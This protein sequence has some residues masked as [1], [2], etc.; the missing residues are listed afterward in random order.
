MGAANQLKQAQDRFADAID[1]LTVLEANN[2]NTAAD[3]DAKT[4]GA[5]DT[6]IPLTSNLF[7]PGKV[8]R[9]AKEAPVLVDI[10]TGYFAEKSTEDAKDYFKRMLGCA[11]ECVCVEVVIVLWHSRAT[12]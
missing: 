6:L 1:S 7:V 3:S 11:N 9:L 5:A 10:G 4:T 2:N 12:R 8:V